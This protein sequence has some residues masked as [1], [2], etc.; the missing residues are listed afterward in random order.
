MEAT[1]TYRVRF[2]ENYGWTAGG[3]LPGLCNER[4]PPPCT[5]VHIGAGLHIIIIIIIIMQFTHI[6]WT[7]VLLCST[8]RKGV[9][10]ASNKNRSTYQGLVEYVT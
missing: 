3:K 2:S 4:T 7:C 8:G 1:M 10:Q 5:G 6:P 9:V